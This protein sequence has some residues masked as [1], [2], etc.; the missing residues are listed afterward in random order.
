MPKL[1]RVN[2]VYRSVQGEGARAGTENVFVRFTGC[3]MKCQLAPGPKSPGGF[4]C[5]TEFE[6]GL[7]CS[8]E[9]LVDRV[10]A[11]TKQSRWVILTGGEP[12]LQVDDALIAALK[13]QGYSIAIETNGSVALPAGLD[14]ITVSPKVAEHCIRQR[15][16]S[17]V[18]YVRNAGQ[19]IPQTVV[20]AGAYYLSPA[21]N[22]EEPDGESLRWC[23]ELCRANPPWKLSIQ[24]HKL[25]GVR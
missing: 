4:D 10:I 9:Q 16:A 7:S 11:A 2:D 24:Q 12:G 5:D 14:W 17:E 3:N 19:G 15:V 8:L 13:S 21:F 23:S 18:R 1:Y 20:T 25:T 6:S 22:G